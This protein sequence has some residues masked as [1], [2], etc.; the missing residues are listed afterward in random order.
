MSISIPTQ[1]DHLAATALQASARLWYLVTVTGQWVFVY[2]IVS[3]YIKSAV[4]GDFEKRDTVLPEGLIAG[5]SIGN[6]ALAG[7]L[8]L[9][10]IITFAGTLQLMPKIRQRALS[11]H[12]WNGRVYVLTALIMSISGL[13]MVWTRGTVGGLAQHV[14]IS[15]NSVVIVICAALAWRHTIKR[16]IATFQGPFL[17][18]LGFAQY[19]LPLAILELYFRSS[20]SKNE[21]AKFVMAAGLVVLTG[22]MGVGIFVTTMGMWLPRL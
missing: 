9:A 15:L 11:F 10:A 22:T 7:H 19:L 8:F 1:R 13:Y 21:Q 12:R 5:D 4:R 3:L 2:Y 16:D 20:D 17:T 14:S 18:F 6:V